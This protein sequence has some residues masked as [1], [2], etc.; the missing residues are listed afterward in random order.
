MPVLCMPL[1]N[2]IKAFVDAQ[3][4]TPYQFCKDTG[5]SQ[6]TGYNLYNDPEYIPGPTALAK[7][8]GTYKVQPGELIIYVPE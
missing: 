3:E 7:I 2:K 1:R 6:N 4:I 8:C 5:L